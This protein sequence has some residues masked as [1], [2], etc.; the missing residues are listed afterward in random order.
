MYVDL[1]SEEKLAA[2]YPVLLRSIFDKPL[3]E[4]PAIGKPPSFLY[5][6]GAV[7]TRTGFKLPMLRDAVLKNSPAVRG[8]T[9]DYLKSFQSGF[10]DFK[11][12]TADYEP[13]RQS[14]IEKVKSSVRRFL[15]YRDEYIE[16]ILFLSMYTDDEA[17]YPYLVSWNN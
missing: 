11:L 7:I 15:P 5:D 4:K 14:F 12:T 3:Y 2:N 6:D 1:S 16:F 9:V 17:G 10:E 8:L 13:S